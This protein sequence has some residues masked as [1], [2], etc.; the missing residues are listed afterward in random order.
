MSDTKLHKPLSDRAKHRLRIAARLMR[1]EGYRF[2][3]GEFYE[4]VLSRIVSLDC[5]QQRRLRDL[6]DWL[7][8]YEIAERE[9]H[10]EPTR[11]RARKTKTKSGKRGA[12]RLGASGAANKQNDV[13][14]PFN[15][16]KLDD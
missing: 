6:V 3:D 7:E 2:D 12:L 8:E 16:R 11:S 4:A 9:I 14:Q 5:S 15:E 13:D 10:G 1:Q